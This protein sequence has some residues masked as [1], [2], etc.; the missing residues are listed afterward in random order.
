MI[1]N[2]N[3]AS[4]MASEVQNLNA[5][6]VTYDEHNKRFELQRL[7]Y[8]SAGNLNGVSFWVQFFDFKLRVFLNKKFL[9]RN[10]DKFGLQT[11]ECE[12]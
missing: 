7:E 8:L 5:V 9:S 4:S 2:E 12:P 3:D 11:L 6:F 1:V 10:F